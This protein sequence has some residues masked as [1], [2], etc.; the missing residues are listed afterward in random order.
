MTHEEFEALQSRIKARA[1]KMWADAGEPEGGPEHFE[2]DARELVALEEVDPPTLDPKE[3]ARPVVE[4]AS[5]QE[6]L[7]EFPT[8]RDQGDEE[9]FPDD[10]RRPDEDTVESYRAGEAKTRRD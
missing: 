8:M 1:Q 3:A 5:I 4:E 10:D 6:N 9:T 7:G 2:E